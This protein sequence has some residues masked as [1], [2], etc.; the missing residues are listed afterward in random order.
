MTSHALS[1][2]RPKIQGCAKENCELYGF[3]GT[4][5]SVIL[6]VDIPI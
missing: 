1:D 4:P 5:L 3:F 2:T 6:V